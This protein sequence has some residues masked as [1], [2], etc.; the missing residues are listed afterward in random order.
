MIGWRTRRWELMWL[1]SAIALIAFV[2]FPLIFMVSTSFKPPEE[3]LTSPPT[4]LPVN[5]TFDNYA[6]A[7]S[8]EAFFRYLANSIM[9]TVATT[10]L[11]IAIGA[12]ATFG[13][14]RL[15]FSGRRT[16][17]VLVVLGQLVP[18][19]A[20]AVPLYQMASGLGL[21]DYLP[22]L[23]LAYLAMSLPVTVW[24]LRSYMRSI[25]QELEE[26]AIVDGCTELGA[27]W[28]IVLPLSAPGIAATASYVFFLVW[29]EFLFV[30]IFT[31]RAE[32]RTLPVG[33]L[34]FV[35][36]YETNW[37][38]LMA[39]SM[40]MAIPAMLAFVLIQ[41]RLIAGLTEG[42]VKA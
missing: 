6:S 13:F 42:S 18:L 38:N 14:T 34:D 29:Q 9:V 41:R 30:L 1:V 39:A 2:V 24:M 32:N 5:P 28:R 25:P 35:G 33:I 31:T 22:A 4:I 7:L 26:A 19:A 23:V 11:S 37:G 12:F 20:I 27:F 10:I 21:I 8:H 3:Q 40:L 16:L 36:Q 15:R 17:L